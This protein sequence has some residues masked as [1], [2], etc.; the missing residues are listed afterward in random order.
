MIQQMTDAHYIFRKYGSLDGKRNFIMKRKYLCL[1]KRYN[2]EIFRYNNA[3]ENILKT[4]FLQYY[5][6]ARLSSLG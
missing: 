2:L 3:G 1:L 6:N 5:V 4:M